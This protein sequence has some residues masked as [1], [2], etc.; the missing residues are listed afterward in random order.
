M[1]DHIY[2]DVILEQHV[3]LFRGAMGAE[4]LFMDDNARLHHANIVDE[5]L[6]SEDIT[7]MY[8]PA[9]SPDLNPIEHVWDML[10]RRIATR[11]PPPTCLPELRRALLDDWCSIPQDQIDNLILSMPRR[12]KACIASSGRHTPY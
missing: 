1:T 10:G 8:W 4:F 9:Y 11:Q 2:R 5:C 7:R 3:R 12:C 6:Q